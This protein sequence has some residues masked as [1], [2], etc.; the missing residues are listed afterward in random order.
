VSKFSY[1]LSLTLICIA[2]SAC[3]KPADIQAVR[4]V[5]TDVEMTITSVT[6]GS[7]VAEKEAQLAFGAVGRVA[8]LN[9]KEGSRVNKGDILAEIENSDL[10]AALQ[11]AEQDYKRSVSLRQ[12]SVLTPQE[13]EHSRESFAMAKGLYEKSIINAP[14]DGMITEVNLEV[15]QLS[16]ITT[17]SPKALIRIV[18]MEPRYI[19]TDVDEVD[20]PRLHVGLPARVKI[21]AVRRQPF[22]GTLRQVIPYVSAA[23]EQDRTS[24]VELSVNSEALLLPPGASAD[25][26]IIAEKHMQVLAVPSRSILGRGSERFVYIFNNGKAQRAA[27]TIGIGNYEKTE[28]L[29]GLKANDI[30]LIPSDKVALVDGLSVKAQVTT[31]P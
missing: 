2:F 11:Q 27:V 18:D 21:L 16:Q 20:L 4:A 30:V 5:P 26:E 7:V 22:I 15:G 13:L 28:I 9:V 14:F 10:K 25:V 17:I 6:S 29:S 8:A 31:W 3:S 1:I 12:S 24:R 19:S 23:R